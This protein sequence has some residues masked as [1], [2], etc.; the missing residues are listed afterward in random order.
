[1]ISG[2]LVDREYNLLFSNSILLL[3]IVLILALYKESKS[4][5]FRI[6]NTKNKTHG[7]TV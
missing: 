1:M 6:F 2:I 3:N 4:N 5:I 7:I